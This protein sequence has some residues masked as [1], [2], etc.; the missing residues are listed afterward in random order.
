MR[1]GEFTVILSCRNSLYITRINL[2]PTFNFDIRNSKTS[3]TNPLVIQQYSTE[4]V[5]IYTNGVMMTYH[6]S[7]P[8]VL[9]GV[10]ITRSLDLCVCFVDRCFS[11]LFWPLCCLFFC[12]L[13]ILTGT[14]LSSN[15]SCIHC[16]RRA[17][18]FKSSSF[19]RQFHLLLISML[20][21][22]LSVSLSD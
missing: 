18:R 2:I 9:S 17:E 5:V 11:F 1:I 19:N 15:S 22:L 21:C 13:W 8:P 12:D 7:S 3:D 20:Y 10:L 4:H 6:L 14:L 16:Y